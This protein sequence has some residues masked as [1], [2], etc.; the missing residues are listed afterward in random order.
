MIADWLG[1]LD[2]ALVAGSIVL[3]LASITSVL[4]RRFPQS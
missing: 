4:Q 1:S 2:G 3:G